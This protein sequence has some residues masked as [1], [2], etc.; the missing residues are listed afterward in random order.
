MQ[1][2]RY[3]S[4]DQSMMNSMCHCGQLLQSHAAARFRRGIG[5]ANC[6]N[7]ICGINHTSG[8]FDRKKFRF[9]EVQVRPIETLAHRLSRIQ[10]P[11]ES[12]DITERD[13]LEEKLLH[14][15]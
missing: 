11:F 8:W 9:R 14:G 5:G 13:V 1:R 15:F 12:A 4:Y 7:A 6:T 10:F 2:C 3:L